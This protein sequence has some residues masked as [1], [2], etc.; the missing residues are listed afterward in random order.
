M[1]CRSTNNAGWTPVLLILAAVII[2]GGAIEAAQ[3]VGSIS[4]AVLGTL[5]F[6]GLAGWLICR[7]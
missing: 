1:T 4:V 2:G 5:G 3:S 7:R 6:L